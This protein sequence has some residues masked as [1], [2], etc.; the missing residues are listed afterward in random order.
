MKGTQLAWIK[1]Q[2]KKKKSLTSMLAFQE[3]GCTRLAAAVCELRGR[4]W[5]ITTQKKDSG[6]G[7]QYAV[8]KLVKAGE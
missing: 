6:N 8:Y 2:L 3:V 5:Q 7:S 4:G 1:A